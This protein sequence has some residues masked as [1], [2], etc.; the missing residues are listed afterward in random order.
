MP[1]Q[2]GE[3]WVPLR[4]ATRTLCSGTVAKAMRDRELLSRGEAQDFEGNPSQPRP[5]LA[6]TRD[7]KAAEAH[8]RQGV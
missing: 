8:L 2:I 4:N 7:K 1:P 5:K 6:V 3:G